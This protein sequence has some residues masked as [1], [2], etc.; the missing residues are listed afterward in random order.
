MTQAQKD[1]AKDQQRIDLVTKLAI[2][3]VKHGTYTAR[4]GLGMVA[5]NKRAMNALGEVP[6][7][8][9][10]VRGVDGFMNPS[11]ARNQKRA[12][13][14]AAEEAQQEVRKSPPPVAEKKGGLS[15]LMGGKER[16]FDMAEDRALVTQRLKG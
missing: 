16:S 15:G 7:A 14:A 11:K 9:G 12:D 10:L 4:T 13:L 2:A 6:G 8:Q 5:G 3:G 1:A